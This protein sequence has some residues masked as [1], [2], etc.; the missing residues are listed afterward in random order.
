[1]MGAGES[2]ANIIPCF[3]QET[4]IQTV[5]QF[6]HREARLVMQQFPILIDLHDYATAD[7]W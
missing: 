2:D 4:A 5:A 6:S 3:R 1:M 7:Y